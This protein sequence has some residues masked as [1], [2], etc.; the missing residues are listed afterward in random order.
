MTW[1]KHK[2][3]TNKKLRKW[4]KIKKEEELEES[5]NLPVYAPNDTLV[6]KDYQVPV[7]LLYFEK[8]FQNNCKEWLKHAKPD[9]YN[10]GYMKMLID[11]ARAEAL[12]EID[13]EEVVL[14]KRVIYELA[15]IWKGDEVK[16]NGK[17]AETKAARKEVEEEL[18]RIERIYY[19]HTAFAPEYLKQNSLIK[20]EEE[21]YE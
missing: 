5:V 20:R 14:H 2:K 15:K 13:D 17:L 4:F 9:M 1:L 21:D 10:R 3:N 6:P 12:V 8:D 18:K 11:K 19:Q 7:S 16:A